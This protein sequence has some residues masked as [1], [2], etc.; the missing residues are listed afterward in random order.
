MLDLAGAAGRRARRR[1]RRAHPPGLLSST[2]QRARDGDAPRARLRARRT[3]GAD[4]HRS[5]AA[6]RPAAHAAECSASSSYEPEAPLPSYDLEEIGPEAVSAPTRSRAF[7]RR[8][9]RARGAR[10]A[11]RTWTTRSARRRS[12]ASRSTRPGERGARSTS[13]SPCS[14]RTPPRSQPSAATRCRADVAQLRAARAR[15]GARG[16]RVL[17]VARA[18]RRRADDP[19]GAARAAA[20]PSAPRRAPGR[21]RRA[22]ARHAG[23]L[24]HA[25]LARQAPAS[26]TARSTSPRRSTRSTRRPRE[27]RGPGRASAGA[28]EQVDVE[29]VFAKFKEGVAKQIGVDDAQSHYDLGVAYKEMGLIDDAIR[30]FDTAARDPKRAC[31]CH[32]MIG[33]DPARA[34]EPQRGHRRLHAGACR[35]PTGRRSR[36]PPSAT[37]SAPPTR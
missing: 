4:A 2:R 27:R 32:S 28:R 36:R 19:R 13:A 14:R 6:R 16:G 26:R 31:V 21:A 25:P 8:L 35:R 33:I 24:G 23:R 22:G 18:L 37:R 1:L 17:R 9:R 11:S 10:P 30:E 12:P 5:A 29:E 7:E 34:R 15:V 3:G 20:E